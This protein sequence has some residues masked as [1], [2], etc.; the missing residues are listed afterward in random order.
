VAAKF[1][2]EN[3]KTHAWSDDMTDRAQTLLDRVDRALEVIIESA[4]PYHGLFPSMMDRQDGKLIIDYAEPIPGQRVNDRAYRGSNLTHDEPTLNTLL[5]L[6]R[7][8]PEYTRAADRYLSRFA[9]HCTVAP[10]GL[11]PWGEHSY[12]DLVEG[13]IGNSFTERGFRQT[14]V[15]HDHLR[16]AP[17]WMWEKLDTFNPDCVQGFARGLI[18]HWTRPPADFPLEYNRHALLFDD[19]PVGGPQLENA[20]DFPRH[21]GFYIYDWAF[22]YTRSHNPLWLEQINRMMTYHWTKR[23]DN[24][25]LFI[26]SRSQPHSTLWRCLAVAQTLSLGSSLLEA[27]VL[28]EPLEPEL[29]TAMRQQA[30]MYIDAHFA[31]PHD[32][33]H[34]KFYHLWNREDPERTRLAQIWGSTY[35]RTPVS[36]SAG[37]CLCVYRQVPDARLLDWAAAAGEHYLREPFPMDLHV[38]AMDA[39]M[40]LALLCDLYDITGKDSWLDG[41]MTLAEQLIPIYFDDK[42]LPR[43]AAGIDWYESQMGPGFLLYGLARTGLLAREGKAC[44]LGPDYTGR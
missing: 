8:K 11:F 41:A 26:E 39:G 30:G 20:P 23:Q 1:V 22:A 24:G 10:T 31:A 21:G 15:T 14:G 44:P 37:N 17:L 19:T 9:N 40:S 29:A 18:G 32:L 7:D 35:G 36:Y 13:A 25:L 34:G 28:L 43:G 4:D 42:P 27:A 33:A 12:W 38:P 6:E 2:A 16:A 3:R 5:A